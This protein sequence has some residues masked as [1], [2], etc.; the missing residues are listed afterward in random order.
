[1]VQ[2]FVLCD[3]VKL[4]DGVKLYCEEKQRWRVKSWY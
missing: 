1:M 4:F 3:G 2:T